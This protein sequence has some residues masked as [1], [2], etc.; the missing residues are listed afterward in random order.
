MNGM[1][2]IWQ[3][4]PDDLV[5]R[6]CNMLHK[7]RSVSP[8]L[9]GELSHRVTMN[10]FYKYLEAYE[11]QY[12]YT[13]QSMDAFCDDMYNILNNWDEEPQTPWLAANMWNALALFSALSDD[14]KRQLWVQ[15]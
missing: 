11:K 15:F 8:I 7:V 5:D 12:Y 13:D 4:L 1:D 6:I 3:T 14:Q 2:P 9:K 10:E